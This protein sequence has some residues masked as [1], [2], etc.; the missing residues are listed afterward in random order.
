MGVK[1]AVLPALTLPL[2]P[3]HEAVIHTAS[4]K[5]ALPRLDGMSSSCPT[6]SQFVNSR[7]RMMYEKTRKLPHLRVPV[8]RVTPDLTISALNEGRMRYALLG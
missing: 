1:S 7:M 3:R 2:M 5:I 8:L 4:T 6:C